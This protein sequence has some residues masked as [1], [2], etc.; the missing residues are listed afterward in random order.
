M[1]RFGSTEAESNS[2]PRQHGRKTASVLAL[3]QTPISA[4]SIALGPVQR[5]IA[6]RI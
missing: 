3:L 6:V 4:A 1:E 5:K 2:D